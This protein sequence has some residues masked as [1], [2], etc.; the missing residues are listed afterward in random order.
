MV[1]P[2]GEA[3]YECRD[4]VHR[5]C[6]ADLAVLHAENVRLREALEKYGAHSRGCHTKGIPRKRTAQDCGPPPPPMAGPCTCG[7]DNALKGET[8]SDPDTDRWHDDGG[9]TRDPE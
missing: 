1:C 9:P 5:Y 4:C 3:P 6:I 7:L 2:H 8:M